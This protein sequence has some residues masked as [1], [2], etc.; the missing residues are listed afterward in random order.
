MGLGRMPRRCGAGRGA[1]DEIRRGAE[2]CAD[3]M[4]PGGGNPGVSPL[5]IIREDR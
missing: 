3:P 4:V 5:L 2:N 1:I